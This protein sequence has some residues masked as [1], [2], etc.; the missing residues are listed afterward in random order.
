MLDH[1]FQ[2][3]AIRFMLCSCVCHH[4]CRTSLETRL[5]LLHS[6]ECKGGAAH[7]SPR[8][9]HVC[10]CPSQLS[11]LQNG[12]AGL[13]SGCREQVEQVLA[14]LVHISS[15]CVSYRCHNGF[16][17]GDFGL[18]TAK[19]MVVMTTYRNQSHHRFTLLLS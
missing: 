9:T 17:T 18:A 12:T 2:S 4:I 5:D 19:R 7:H 1:V 11:G 16:K 15:G 3:I 6:C 13:A 10:C 14:F 8:M